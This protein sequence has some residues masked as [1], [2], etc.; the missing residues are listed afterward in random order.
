L[1]T[2]LLKLLRSKMSAGVFVF[3]V[4]ATL[5][6]SGALLFSYGNWLRQHLVTILD[7]LNT[8]ICLLKISGLYYKHMTIVNYASSVVNKLKALLT[9]DAKVVIYDHHVF[10]VHA[11][12]CRQDALL[13]LIDDMS[14]WL[15]IAKPSLP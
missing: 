10:I 6:L 14:C 13:L 5:I 15:F 4:I 12:A 3:D 8:L 7:K 11:T 2:S 1:L 9:D